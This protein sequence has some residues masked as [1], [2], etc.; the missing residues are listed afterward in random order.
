MRMTL[1]YKRQ[2]AQLPTSTIILLQSP[3]SFQLSKRLLTDTYTRK[4]GFFDYMTMEFPNLCNKHPQPPVQIRKTTTF[5]RQSGHRTLA[6]R[7]L[8]SAETLS[9]KGISNK[10]RYGRK[11]LDSTKV[12][13]IQQVKFR[14]ICCAIT[15]SNRIHQPARLA[16][17]S[18][19]Q[20]LWTTPIF[21]AN[22]PPL[23]PRVQT[24]KKSGVAVTLPCL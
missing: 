17:R 7:A 23:C 9:T 6:A 2:S 22:H 10:C 19:R 12:D 20:V 16:P 1:G 13:I 4:Q 21:N 11:I 15:H 5:P 3:S 24:L 14:G 18:D 8:T